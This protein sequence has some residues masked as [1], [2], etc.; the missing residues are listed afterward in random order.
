MRALEYG[1]CTGLFR[2]IAGFVRV[3]TGCVR[4]SFG[5]SAPSSSKSA[6][7]EYG[8]ILT[9]KQPK[10][11]HRQPGQRL[12]LCLRRSTF[13]MQEEASSPSRHCV[14][15]PHECAIHMAHGGAKLQGF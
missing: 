8:V 3:I 7:F 4:V 12:L 11:N 13:P 5:L 6:K 14:I 1:F 10:K 9:C 2:V 15:T